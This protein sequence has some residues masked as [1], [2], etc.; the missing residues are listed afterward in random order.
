MLGYLNPGATMLRTASPDRTDNV[1]AYY[2]RDRI[3]TALDRCGLG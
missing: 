2:G 3:R 1:F